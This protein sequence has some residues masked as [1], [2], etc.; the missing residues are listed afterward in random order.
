MT[1]LP[2]DAVKDIGLTAAWAEAGS[3]VEDLD[4]VHVLSFSFERDDANPNVADLRSRIAR[5]IRDA[6]L[7]QG[8]EHHALVRLL[9][10]EAWAR[11]RF[12]RSH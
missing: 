3:R 8:D 9:G 2:I 6:L 1:T 11:S 4:V 7:A 12:A 10:R 5:S